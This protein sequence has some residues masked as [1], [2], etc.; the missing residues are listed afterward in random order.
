VCRALHDELPACRVLL[1]AEHDDEQT[2]AGLSAGAYGCYLLSDPPLSLVRAIRGT[3]RRESLPTPE[4]ARRVLVHYDELTAEEAERVVP[5]P[6]LT[7]TETEVLKRLADGKTPDQI[8]EQHDVTAHL[9]RLH[10]G[11]AIIKLYRALAD[12]SAVRS[13]A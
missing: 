6:R 9:V 10:A 13:S 2:Y 4:W 5:T 11:Y 7:P 1:L 3:M 8:G 12:E